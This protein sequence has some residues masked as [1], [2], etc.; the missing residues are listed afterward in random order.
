MSMMIEFSSLY[1]TIKKLKLYWYFRLYLL[2]IRFLSKNMEFKILIWNDI[3]MCKGF[4]N[5]DKANDKE[6]LIHASGGVYEGYWYNDKTHRGI[7]M[8]KVI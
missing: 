5:A 4:R 2:N 3:S 8:R 6:R 7:E 1:Q